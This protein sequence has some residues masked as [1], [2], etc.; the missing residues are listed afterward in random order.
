MALWDGDEEGRNKCFKVRNIFASEI[1]FCVS[2]IH[3]SEFRKIL[4][5]LSRRSAF[6][7][8]PA[9]LRSSALKTSSKGL[10]ELVCTPRGLGCRTCGGGA[11]G[12][13]CTCS[14]AK[15]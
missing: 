2:S 10:A 4:A 7:W 14:V 8:A 3:S 5:Q 11:P 6:A 12:Q 1:I 15:Q 9:K 13:V